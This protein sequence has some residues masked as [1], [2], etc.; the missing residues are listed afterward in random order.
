MKLAQL[1]LF[2]SIQLIKNGNVKRIKQVDIHPIG[3][4][5]SSRKEGDEIINWNQTSRSLFNFIRS[6]CK[7]GPSV[8]F[9]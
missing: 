7:P 3:F 8:N 1:V 9:L 4:Y 2:K 5:C 6:I